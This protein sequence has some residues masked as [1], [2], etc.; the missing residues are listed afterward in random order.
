MK[1]KLLFL[2]L[3]TLLT[4]SFSTAEVLHRLEVELAFTPPAELADQHLGYRLLKNGVQV[5]E[6][7]DAKASLITCDF[8]TEYGTFD[9]SL[10]AYFVND[11]ESQASEPF[12]FTISAPETTVVLE[13]PTAVLSSSTAVG[14]APLVVNFDGSS[15][16]TPNPPIVNYSWTF[17]DGDQATGETTSHS[18]TTAGTYETTLTVEDFKGLTNSIKTPIIITST[19]APNEKPTAVIS[20]NLPGGDA[21]VT[22]T[23]DGSKSSDT[24]G[25]IT[26]YSWNFGDD[27]TGFGPKVE[28]TYTAE[29]TYTVVL[30]VTDDKGETATATSQIACTPSTVNFNIE[31]G[32]V[33]IG[34]TSV[35]VDFENKNFI[36]PIIVAGPPSSGDTNPVLVRISKVD[37]EGFDIRLQEWDYQKDDAGHAPETFSYIVMEKGLYTLAN[38]AKIEAGSFTG[39][40][41]FNKVSLQQTYNLTP[42]ILTQVMTYNDQVA[43]T[44]RIR[45]IGPTSFDY[46]LQTQEANRTAHGDETV[47]YIAWEPGTGEIG[48]MLYEAGNTADSVTHDWTDLTFDTEFPALPHFIAGMQTYDSSE[49]AAVRSNNMSQAAT[50]IKIEEEQSKDAEI[51]H[52][53]EVVGYLVI[54][55]KTAAA[56]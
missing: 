27:A 13:P 14:E 36:Q 40:S 5:C 11:T 47:G 18:F 25:S 52:T 56:E 51:E 46:M 55:S 37:K 24:D 44:G 43:V 42:V 21:P 3:V 39:I 41:R 53:T 16:T 31:V 8:L 19:V 23:F 6:T 34:H 22:I 10:K 1:N 35:R 30:T 50:Q 29:G 7:I 38:G 9:F 33:L 48:N 15:S 20:S 12:P 17:G 32:E 49:T 2:L 28:H 54:G 45:K 4:P 26:Q